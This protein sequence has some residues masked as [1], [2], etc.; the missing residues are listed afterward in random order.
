MIKGELNGDSTPANL[1][2]DIAI[3]QEAR[4]KRFAAIVRF[5][6]RCEAMG[7]AK[8]MMTQIRRD[9]RLCKLLYDYETESELIG[10]MEIVHEL[11]IKSSSRDVS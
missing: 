11:K 6:R 1:I 8:D 7:P 10:A 5:V 9:H 4:E 3:A 2:R